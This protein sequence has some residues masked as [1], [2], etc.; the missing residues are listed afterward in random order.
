M[1]NSPEIVLKHSDN[2]NGCGVSYLVE[3]FQNC[4]LAGGTEPVSVM[5]ALVRSP[6]LIVKNGGIDE[7]RS[8][9]A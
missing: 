9:H 7:I 6:L 3:E 4:A 1:I 5:V 2:M 8:R